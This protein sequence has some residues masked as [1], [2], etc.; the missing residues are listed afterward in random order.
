MKYNYTIF[1]FCLFIYTF[2]FSQVTFDSGYF[3]NKDGKRTECLIKNIEWKNNPT[4]FRYK[5][6]ENSE[7]TTVKINDVE[8]FGVK[9]GVVF[10]KYTVDL[11]RSLDFTIQSAGDVSRQRS[12]IFEKEELFL[13]LLIDG[14]AKLYYYENNNLTRFFYARGEDV[15]IQLVHKDFSIDNGISEN[16]GFRQQL[17][18]QLKCDK[19][20]INDIDELGYK[21]KELIALFEKYN[22][23]IDPNFVV[24]DKVKKK[25]L[26]NLSV[27]LGISSSN[28]TFENNGFIAI[29]RE[30]VFPNVTSFR[31]GVESEFIL[32][33]NRNKWSVIFEPYYQS[34]NAEFIF[35]GEFS[36]VERSYEVN[37]TS[38]DFTAGVRYYMFLNENSKLFLNANLVLGFNTNSLVT[39]EDRPNFEVVNSSNLAFSIG[40]AYKKFTLEGRLRRPR[41]I[42]NNTESNFNGYSVILGYSLF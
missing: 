26:F 8:E 17:F 29:P 23:C 34:Y 35:M 28:L 31:F 38:I 41:G 7:I 36:G 9:G 40:Y 24:F 2:G 18:I 3:I 33:F 22:K 39:I 15:P 37:Y 4:S 1:L 16:N 19:I 20:S 42:L 32:N 27:R 5:N 13:K 6:T 11:D 30:I 14:E 25:D 12:P 21:R 10:K